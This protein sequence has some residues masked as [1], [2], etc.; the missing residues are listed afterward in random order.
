MMERPR[1][2]KIWADPNQR[3]GLGGKTLLG[4]AVLIRSPFGFAWRSALR[5]SARSLKAG[6]YEI[7][8]NAT[9]LLILSLLEE[10]KVKKHMVVFYEGGT[11]QELARLLEAEKLAEG[12]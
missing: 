3:P 1:L 8:Q 10:G 9:T 5:G 6:E 11:V 12:A 2:L 7:P 4:G